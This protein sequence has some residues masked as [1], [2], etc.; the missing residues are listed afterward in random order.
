MHGNIEAFYCKDPQKGS[1]K[2]ECDKI[3]Q[4]SDYHGSITAINGNVFYI[5]SSQ[6]M[7][8]CYWLDGK[9]LLPFYWL[10]IIKLIFCRENILVDPYNSLI[11]KTTGC[12]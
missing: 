1:C 2:L 4:Q 6:L 12:L 3:I 5:H 10:H 9:Y 8:R 11:W 7:L